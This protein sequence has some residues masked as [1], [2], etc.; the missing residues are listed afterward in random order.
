MTGPDGELVATPA[1]ALDLPSSDMTGPDGE[2]VATPECYWAFEPKQCIAGDFDSK[3][4]ITTEAW[5]RIK[6]IN[7]DHGV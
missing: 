7:D 2:L 4:W 3:A 1:S 5:I 6:I